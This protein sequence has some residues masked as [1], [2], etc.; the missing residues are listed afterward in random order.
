MGGGLDT[1]P[2]TTPITHDQG[3]ATRCSLN[4]SIIALFVFLNPTNR[5]DTSEGVVPVCKLPPGPMGSSSWVLG[6]DHPPRSR[7]LDNDEELLVQ[8][9]FPSTTFRPANI[10]RGTAL[11][12]WAPPLSSLSPVTAVGID[13][14]ASELSAQYHIPV[15][16]QT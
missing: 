7:W 2:A 16:V 12:T 14:A 11:V 8:R 9:S 5:L 1:G 13:S 10:H 6:Q 3:T 15:R 4:V